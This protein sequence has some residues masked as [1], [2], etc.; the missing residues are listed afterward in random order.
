MNFHF[1]LVAPQLPENIGAAARAMNTMG[2]DHLRLVNPCDHLNE[3]ARWI[4]HGSNHILETAEIYNSF[5]NALQDLDF[6]IGST[7]RRR[8][9]R[10]EY[11]T[12]EQLRALVEKKG[13][14]I[15][16]VG[17]VF[18]R[19]NHGLLNEEIDRCDALVTLTMRAAYPSLNL[20]QAVMVFSYVLSPFVLTSEIY[21]AAPPHEYEFKSLKERVAGI[22]DKIGLYQ[23]PN[24]VNRLMER[25]G[26]CSEE[27]VHLLHSVCNKLERKIT[28]QDDVK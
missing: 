18:G 8:A 3:R 15:Q 2:F 20:A 11:F 24:I 1:I 10:Q 28:D 17:V 14:S 25:L 21:T 23:N 16:N 22:F 19:E 9:R 4:A 13:Q 27:D 26:H 12:G 7:A 5:E 6:I